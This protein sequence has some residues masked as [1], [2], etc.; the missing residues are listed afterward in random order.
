M[1]S[2]VAIAVLVVALVSAVPVAWTAF[3][4]WNAIDAISFM[5]DFYISQSTG[6][7]FWWVGFVAAWMVARRKI[8]RR[9]VSLSILVSLSFGLI[10]CTWLEFQSWNDPKHLFFPGFFFIPIAGSLV[11]AA[12][13]KMLSNHQFERD[14]NGAPR[15]KL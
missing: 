15:L 13:A 11:I 3:L 10:A 2:G 12:A 6:F 8:Q 7:L 1:G 5:P 14:A 9:S 4:T